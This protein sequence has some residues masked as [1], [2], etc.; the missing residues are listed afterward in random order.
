MA[1]SRINWIDKSFFKY[2]QSKDNFFLNI[3]PI[4]NVITEKNKLIVK[5]KTACLNK[6]CCSVIIGAPSPLLLD[7]PK[8]NKPKKKQASALINTSKLL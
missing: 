8:K 6:T 5:P 1:M 7:D 4:N 3:I 2:L